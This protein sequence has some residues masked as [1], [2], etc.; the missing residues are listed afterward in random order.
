MSHEDEQI[1]KIYREL[2]RDEIRQV[3]L[4]AEKKSFIEA[5]FEP[6]PAFV[7]RPD[8]WVPGFVFCA[9]FALLIRVWP[10]TVPQTSPHA[11]AAREAHETAAAAAPESLPLPAL[12]DMAEEGQITVERVAS[13]MGMPV[14]YQ[15]Q[16]NNVPVTVIWVI[17]RQEAAQGGTLQGRG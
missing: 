16:V 13:D 8:F 4:E 9:A 11:A 15:R 6:A 14:I 2:I 7:F 10:E 17:P 12:E 5:H 1:G 3:D